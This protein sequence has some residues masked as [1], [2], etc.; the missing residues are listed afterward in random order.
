[1]YTGQRGRFA[2]KHWEMC[3]SEQVRKIIGQVPPLPVRSGI[4]II[5]TI[6]ALLLAVA[7]FVPYP[8]TT[9][10]D[11]VL[12]GVREGQAFVTGELPYACITRIS[13]GMK[14]EVEPEEYT[15]REYGYLQGTVTAVSPRIISRNGH[16]YFCF[17]LSLKE[18]PFMQKGMKGKASVI[19]SEKTL[20]ERI[21]H[22]GND[23]A[24]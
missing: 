1:M 19:L 6:V 4:G 20:L 17:T 23:T 13:P 24:S 2:R 14:A 12:T 9:E 22:S 7:A 10:T 3:G 21:L 15:G 5:G 16:N 11:I 18:V 8:E